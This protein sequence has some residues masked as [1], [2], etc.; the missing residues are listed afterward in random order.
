MAAVAK[1]H[2]VGGMWIQFLADHSF[3]ANPQQKAIYDNA[4]YV[5]E[6]DDPSI[7]VLIDINGKEHSYLP[8]LRTVD[9][10]TLS[11][12]IQELSLNEL[13]EKFGSEKVQEAYRSAVRYFDFLTHYL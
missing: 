12:R 11:G 3:P 2:L 10:V 9:S 1:D 4:F 13:E 5:V 7:F 6:I 8:A